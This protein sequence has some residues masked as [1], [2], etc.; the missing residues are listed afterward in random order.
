MEKNLSQAYHDLSTL[1]DAG[2]PILRS[3]KT[4]LP[5]LK[6]KQKKAFEGLLESVSQGDSL[7][8]SMVMYPRVFTLL[9]VSVIKAA[10]ISGN[11]PQLLK[12]LS[13]WYE[14]R[15]RLKRIVKSGL[16]LPFFVLHIAAIFPPL[17]FFLVGQTSF[18]M[19]CTSV[20]ST[21]AVFYIPAILIYLVFTFTPK[22]GFF[23]RML[24]ETLQIV[25]LLGKSLM[26]LALSRYC[27]SFNML[28]SAG[29]PITQCAEI[30]TSTAGNTSISE[31]LKGGIEC[32]KR[33]K[34]VSKG[35]SNSLPNE[36]I[37]L[38][39]IGEESGELE[40]VTKKMAEYTSDKA[41]FMLTQIMKWVP[42]ILY[43]L[44]CLLIVKEIFKYASVI[45]S[46]HQGG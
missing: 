39:K 31:L 24:D 26:Y 11:L 8:E 13:E 18:T 43:F 20:L 17:I 34:P 7:S 19:F 22:K 21:L 32:T 46:T 33:G 42:R 1:L 28:Y 3:L 23:R 30:S 36:F 5:G 9:D 41:E 6:G 29:V 14:F 16:L 27:S 4:V 25:P 10:D 12:M 15:T 35:F 2:V 37:S 38:W 40:K 45:V 44:V